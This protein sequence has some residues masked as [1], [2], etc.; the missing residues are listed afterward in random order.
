VQRS[1]NVP[2]FSVRRFSVF[3][4]NAAS[5]QRCCP[6]CCR[7]VQYTIKTLDLRDGKPDPVGH[8]AGASSYYGLD[9]GE[10]IYVSKNY[11]NPPIMALRLR[12]LADLPPLAGALIVYYLKVGMTLAAFALTFRLVEDSAIRSRHGKSAN[13]TF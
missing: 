13:G 5:W 1:A 12:P 10:N 6:V 9:G 11:P 7:R 3:L 2:A 4:P 8:L